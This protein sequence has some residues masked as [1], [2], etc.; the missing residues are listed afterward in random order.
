MFDELRQI[1][2]VMIHVIAVPRLTGAAVP[3][4]VMRDTTEPVV[5]EESHL[6]F[7]RIGGERPAV[8][9]DDGLAAAPVLVVNLR[10]VLCGDR[11]TGG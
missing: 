9:E 6:V 2:G 10:T 3:A 11:P 5:R 1:V 8:A 4:T 7:K